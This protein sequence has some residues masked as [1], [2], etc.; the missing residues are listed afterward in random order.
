MQLERR[1]W[2][3]AT[4]SWVIDKGVHNM[5]LIIIVLRYSLLFFLYLFLFHMVRLVYRSLN[6]FDPQS[7]PKA[8]LVE[9]GRDISMGKKLLGKENMVSGYAHIYFFQ[10][11]YWLEKIGNDKYPLLNF[12]V[13]E[14]PTPLSSGDLIETG[15]VTLQFREVETCRQKSSQMLG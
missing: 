15:V 3:F 6:T 11:R 14:G 9:I 1:R 12:G 13:L 4:V 2:T 8:E 10:G 5:G 7:L